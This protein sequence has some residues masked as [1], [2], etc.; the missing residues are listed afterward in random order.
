[1]DHSVPF[2]LS[3]KGTFTPELFISYPAS[4]HVVPD[5]HDTPYG[6]V[7]FAPVGAGTDWSDHV[8]PFHR[9]AHGSSTLELFSYQPTAVQAFDAVQDTPDKRLFSVPVGSV[10]VWIFHSVPFH[11]SVNE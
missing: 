5:V 2:Q 4:A 7:A 10:M 6:Y 8:V 9:A 3:A 11:V 1:M